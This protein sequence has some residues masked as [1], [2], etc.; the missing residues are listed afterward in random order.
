M[1]SLGEA[2]FAS[3]RSFVIEPF[4]HEHPKDQIKVPKVL[5]M[6]FDAD[7]V[8][9][10]STA[11]AR[12]CQPHPAWF[13]LHS[14]VYVFYLIEVWAKGRIRA[15]QIRLKTGAEAVAM[16]AVGT[17]ISPRP[18]GRGRR[19]PSLPLP[20]NVVGRMIIIEVFPRGCTPRHRPT[21]CARTASGSV[22][23]EPNPAMNSRRRM[24]PPC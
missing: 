19:S 7:R 20:Q 23:T 18:P 9:R 22:A 5:L 17:R 12:I 3:D 13:L 6:P 4:A 21:G 2:R 10:L 14:A 15:M 24:C 11:K 1:S 8:V 16:V